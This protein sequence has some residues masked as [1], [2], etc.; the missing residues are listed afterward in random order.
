MAPR[1]AAR[2]TSEPSR[3]RR[4]RWV[5]GGA[6]AA[7]LA[8]AM[9]VS[10]STTG[11]ATQ[12]PATVVATAPAPEQATPAPSVPATGIASAEGTAPVAALAAAA[13]PEST[14]R[15]VSAVAPPRRPRPSAASVV[16]SRVDVAPA[17]AEAALQAGQSGN[18]FNLT[19][20]EALTAR[21]WPRATLGTGATS[22]TARYG[23]AG[24]SA[25]E[26]PSFYPF[27]PRPQGEP[28]TVPTP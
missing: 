28:E 1:V 19:G 23:A 16:A 8:L 20:D 12:D 3:V 5:G 24:E 4:M 11:P 26:R 7:S 14:A 21:P 15:G 17:V 9:V 18:P 25:A 27:E 10:L 13:D 22:F 6:L 2:P